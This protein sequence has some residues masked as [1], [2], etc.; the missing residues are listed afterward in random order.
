MDVSNTSEGLVDPGGA[1][2]GNFINYYQFNPAEERT[3]HLPEDL[4][5]DLFPAGASKLY[6][7]DIGCNAGNLSL[8]LHR[9][10]CR[11]NIRLT[12]LG[13]DIDQILIKRAQESLLNDTSD[14]LSVA[15]DKTIN[16]IDGIISDKEGSSSK[17]NI[18]DTANNS[19]KDATANIKSVVKVTTDNDAKG[20]EIEKPKCG[21]KCSHVKFIHADVMSEEG[22]E[23]VSSFLELQNVQKFDMIFLFSVSMWIHLHHGDEGLSRL[24]ETC[25]RISRYTLLEPQPWK[26]YQTATRRMRRNGLPEFPHWSQIKLRGADLYPGIL[27]IARKQNMEVVKYFGE[28]RWNRKL[29][30]LKSG[31]TKSTSV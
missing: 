14:V 15:N 27:G 11:D 16:K 20:D 4:F 13:A 22:I 19:I 21:D 6:A 12:I 23:K 31:C 29:L 18:D 9:R 10:Y 28:T 25:S 17:D 5:T 24:L 8:A 26:C 1:R 7:L 3:C 2:F 30:L